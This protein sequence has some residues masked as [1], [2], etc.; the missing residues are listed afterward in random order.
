M[1]AQLHALPG[2]LRLRFSL[3]KKSPARLDCVC[4]ALRGIRGMEHVEAS[5][6]TGAI[7]LR[8]DGVAANNHRFWDEVEAV[9]EYNHL[10][11]DQ[12]EVERSEKVPSL[13]HPVTRLVRRSARVL[14]SVL[15]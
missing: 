4:E 11:H 5:A 14:A 10:Y 3:L 7:D 15:R 13:R 8:Y 1:S 9:L 12:R 2:S 6:T